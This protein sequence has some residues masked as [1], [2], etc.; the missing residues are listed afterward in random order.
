MYA[1]R[2]Q[3]I[4]YG[5]IDHLDINFPFDG[6]NPQPVLLVGENG[7]GKSI[8]LSH[9]VNGLLA[10]QGVVYQENSEVEQGKV[11]KL[12]SPSYIKTG[13]E[14]YFGRVDFEENLYQKELQL[15]R[16]KKDCKKPVEF[17]GKDADKFNDASKLWQSM[18]ANKASI[19]DSSFHHEKEKSSIE[20]FFKSRCVLYFPP[21]R[22]EEPAWL[23]EENLRAKAEYMGLKNLQ[24]YTNRKIINDSPLQDNQNWLFEVLYD[25]CAFEVQTTQLPWNTKDQNQKHL[26][27]NLPVFTGHTGTATT[28]YESAL[29]IVRSIFRANG[30]LRLGIGK[31]QNRRVSLMQGDKEL[32]PNIFQ[33]SSGETSLLNLFLSIL[34]DFDLSG[35]RFSKAGD[36]KGIVVVDEIDLHLHVI[37][38][39]EI[40]PQLMKMFPGVQF[41]VATHSPLFVL[42]MKKTF[43]EDGFALY[44][45][46]H[47]QLISPEEFS[48]FGN[49]YQS[50]TETE[51]FKDDIKVEIENAQKPVVFMDGKTDVKYLQKAAELLNQEAVLEKLQLMDGK[52]Y[53]NLNKIWKI[54]DSRLSG[55]I[56]QKVILLHDCDKPG[57]QTKGK[58]FRR[59]IPRQEGHP[60]EKGIE[61]LFEKATIEKA[62]KHKLAFIVITTEHKKFKPDEEETVPEK[63]EVN[64]DEKTNL[65]NW[66]C[67][68]GTGEDFKHFHMIFDLLEKILIDD[69]DANATPLP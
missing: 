47:G 49:A 69:Q 7:S 8:F 14:Y 10:A 18:P 25:R 19:P 12:R 41:I 52:G 48:E 51:R 21:N 20:D 60:L 27:I 13:T 2:I 53:G 29:N 62:R 22:F 39:Y 11:Y 1:K 57:C 16:L 59:N 66:L 4:N 30:N 3:I 43:G 32:V 26:S 24:G 54:F 42:G 68:N 58:V 46:P 36:V 6:E 9:I 40:L 15:Q 23:N 33:L 65:C 56:P 50:F 31:R 35:S 28:I 44:R 17:A 64:D 37:H 45:L 63:W 67:E 34:R 61:N 55:M 38:Q 5:P